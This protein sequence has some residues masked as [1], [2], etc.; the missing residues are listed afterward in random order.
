MRSQLRIVLSVAAALV[1]AV[2]LGAVGYADDTSQRVSS[3]ADVMRTRPGAKSL[4]GQ[5]DFGTYFTVIS[6]TLPAGSW[7]IT[8]NATASN[9]GN[10]DLVRCRLQRGNVVIA[11]AATIVSSANGLAGLNPIG[12]FRSSV[13]QTVSLRC[14]HDG[15]HHGISIAAGAVLW[16]HRSSSLDAS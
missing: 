5:D 4:G 6:V 10:G 13:S 15:L 1:L 7:V 14:A 9:F 3:N 2:S 12:S 16:A 8:A 11:N